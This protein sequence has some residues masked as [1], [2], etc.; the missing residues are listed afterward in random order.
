MIELLFKWL[1]QNLKIKRFIGESK[2]AISIQIYVA[3]ICYALLSLFKNIT[4]SFSSSLK[5][6]AARI[7]T[8]L[9]CRPELADRMRK[10]K[11]EACF[12]SRQLKWEF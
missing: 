12:N 6:V 9:F 11:E 5:D 4:A 8:T 2:N 3:I 7:K 1:K 10:K